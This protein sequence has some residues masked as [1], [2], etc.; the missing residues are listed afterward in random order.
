MGVFLLWQIGRCFYMVACISCT[1]PPVKTYNYSGSM[2]QLENGF[3]NFSIEN[4]NINC[5][6]S[7]RGSSRIAARD[8]EIKMRM[9]NSDIVCNLVIYDFNNNTKLD[10]EEIHDTTHKTGGNDAD[11]K[12]VENLLIEF[13]KHYL[14]KFQKDQNVQLKKPFLNFF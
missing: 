3:K 13:N 6:I 11:D 8:V 7:H 10:I 5:E 14:I 2:D 9:N 4:S 1:T 12:N